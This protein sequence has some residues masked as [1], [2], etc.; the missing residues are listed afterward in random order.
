MGGRHSKSSTESGDGTTD[1]KKELRSFGNKIK[2]AVDEEL[3]RRM[4]VQREVQMSV[5]I[6]KAR[7]TIQIYGSAWGAL[8]SGVGAAKLAG[9]NVP[10]IVGVPIIAGALVLGNMADMAYGNKLS[11]VS[12]EAEYILDNERARLVPLK[13]APVARFYTDEERAAMYDESTAAGLLWP[14]SMFSRFFVPKVNDVDIEP[15]SDV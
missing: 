1:P 7:D 11:R 10:P 9:R 6:A 12:K 4:M 14:S 8:V 5:N 15:K 3:S 2:D 13:Q